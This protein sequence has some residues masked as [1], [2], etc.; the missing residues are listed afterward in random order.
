MATIYQKTPGA[1]IAQ[2]GRNVETFESGLVRLDQ[3][4]VCA[5]ADVATHRQ[6]LAVGSAWPGSDEGPCMDGCFVFPQ[7]RESQDGG[8]FTT[9]HVSGYGRS[10]SDIT[11]SNLV[12][13]DYYRGRLRYARFLP[14]GIV[15]LPTDQSYL[16]TS[17]DLQFNDDLIEP[18]AF[19]YTDRY[20]TYDFQSIEL[21]STTEPQRRIISGLSATSGQQ[22]TFTVYQK[23]AKRLYHVVFTDTTDGST[24]TVPVTLYDPVIQITNRR[25]F[26]AFAEVEF[27]S[28]MENPVEIGEEF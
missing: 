25:N 7:P 17:G 21:I 5:N 13:V 18:F 22:A 1:I 11:I 15:V 9:F 19:D 27:V 8:G 4:F 24:S 14:Q 2:P 23:T 6:S 20:P 12:R 10:T 16:I 3:Q 28:S 26:G